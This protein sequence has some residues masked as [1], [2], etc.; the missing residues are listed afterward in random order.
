MCF[1]PGPIEKTT[2]AKLYPVLDI[3]YNKQKDEQSNYKCA[4]LVS[5]SWC[6]INCFLMSILN[7]L[8]FRHFMSI[9]RPFWP[10][11]NPKNL[12]FSPG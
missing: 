12:L 8:I 7:H 9:S 1:V 3:I 11:P 4:I 6:I 5:K 10:Y 2:E